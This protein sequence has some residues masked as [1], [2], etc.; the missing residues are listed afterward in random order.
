MG[1]SLKMIHVLNEIKALN[2]Q[3]KSD[4]CCIQNTGIGAMRSIKKNSNICKLYIHPSHG[5]GV[6]TYRQ[7]S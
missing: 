3:E 6:S 1:C 7:L 2:G 5:G 4:T